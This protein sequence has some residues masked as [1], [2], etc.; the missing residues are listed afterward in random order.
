MLEVQLAC[1]VFYSVI[2]AEYMPTPRPIAE[3]QEQGSLMTIMERLD[4]TLWDLRSHF[5]GNKP[6]CLK[7]CA[8][9]VRDQTWLETK[10][11]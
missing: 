5:T 3:M 4:R 10:L 6:A 7:L 1:E 2:L 11:T 8:D 9:L